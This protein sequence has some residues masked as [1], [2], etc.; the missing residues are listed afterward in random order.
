MDDGGW[1]GP[2]VHERWRAPTTGEAQ[3][4]GIVESSGRWRRKPRP[5][6]SGQ[7]APFLIE[8]SRPPRRGF[9]AAAA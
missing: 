1:A 9:E 2:T 6:P 7:F 4:R 8:F 3:G 5:M